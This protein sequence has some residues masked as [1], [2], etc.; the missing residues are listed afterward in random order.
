MKDKNDKSYGSCSGSVISATAMLTAAHCLE[1][2]GSLTIN[3]GS[4]EIKAASFSY[5]PDYDPD[6]FDSIDVGVVISSSPL[7]QPIV[8]I[9]SSR[10]ANVGETAVIAGYGQ[11]GLASAGRTLRAGR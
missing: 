4:K 9:L 11:A 6:R 10:D 2:V 3:F 8:P 7:G 5:S 1:D